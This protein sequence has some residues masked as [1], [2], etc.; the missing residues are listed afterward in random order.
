MKS[1]ADRLQFLNDVIP[2]AGELLSIEEFTRFVE[3]PVEFSYFF[4]IFEKRYGLSSVKLKKVPKLLNKDISKTA[5]QKNAAVQG[6]IWEGEIIPRCEQPA[7]R[8]L[9]CTCKRFWNHLSLKKNFDLYMNFQFHPNL[10]KIFKESYLSAYGGYDV[11]YF[12]NEV[13]TTAEDRPLYASQQEKLRLGVKEVTLTKL[14]IIYGETPVKVK[15]FVLNWDPRAWKIDQENNL[16]YT[17]ICGSLKFSIAFQKSIQKS[18]SENLD[19]FE[20]NFGYFLTRWYS[21]GT[22]YGQNREEKN[23]KWTQQFG[24][25]TYRIQFEHF[26]DSRLVF[27]IF[28]HSSAREMAYILN[29]SIGCN[30]QH[31]KTLS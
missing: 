18:A 13:C 17:M 27:K 26:R 20:D 16:V 22:I 11:N 15:S 12:E 10:I 29:F 9:S 23:L 31:L 6:D 2:L 28:G 1:R 5:A 8:I 7:L 30:L 24:K 14:K 19:L 21:M 25:G 4:V 3:R